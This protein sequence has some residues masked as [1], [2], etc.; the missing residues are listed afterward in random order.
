MK[1]SIQNKLKLPGVVK[2]TNMI[3]L[4]SLWL[5]IF[6]MFLKEDSFAPQGCIFVI[7]ITVN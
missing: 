5:A 1:S 4:S 7:K 2:I 6:F 3:Y